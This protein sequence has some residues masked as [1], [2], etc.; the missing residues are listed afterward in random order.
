MFGFIKKTFIR[1]LTSLV[2]A[3]NYTKCISLNNQQCMIQPTLIKLNFN[4]YS[5]AL[6]Y[7][8]FAVNL[9]RCVG[10]RNTLND[11]STKV[12]VPN[13]AEDLNI[14]MFLI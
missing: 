4:E 13:T 2:N 1:L 14:H 5:Q 7:F 12:Y 8:P 3:S 6:L 9:D 11:L 10:S